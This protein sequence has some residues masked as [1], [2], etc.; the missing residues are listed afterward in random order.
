MSDKKP[1]VR[2]DKNKHGIRRETTYPQKSS[3]GSRKDK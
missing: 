1:E 2:I 3:K